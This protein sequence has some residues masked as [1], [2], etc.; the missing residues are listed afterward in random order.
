[1]LNLRHTTLLLALALTIPSAYPTNEARTEAAL[2]CAEAPLDTAKAGAHA[3][4]DGNR[5]RL[6]NWNIHKSSQAGWRDDLRRLADGSDLL[7]LQEA[8]LEHKLTDAMQTPYHA[9]F[10]PGYRTDSSQTGVMT[11]SRVPATSHCFL[12]HQEPWLRTPKATSISRF[13]IANREEKLLVV[14][15]HGVNFALSS[16]SLEHQFRDA[17]VQIEHHKGPVIF[18]GDFNTWSEER[19]RS[20]SAILTALQLRPIAFQQDHRIQVFGKPLDHIYVRGLRTLESGS[21]PVESSDHN[22]IFAT[23]ALDS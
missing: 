15:L 20:V 14:N 5:I 1:M 8:T 4:L 10:A 12:S 3:A 11:L 23:F 6:M 13:S 9:V 19:M 21:S 17:S 16:E 2:S 18:S 7:L 22:P